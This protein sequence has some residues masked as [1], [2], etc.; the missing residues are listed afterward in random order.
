MAASQ[1]AATPEAVLGI[2]RNVLNRPDIRLDDDVFDHGATSLAFVRVL[3]QI[4]QEFHVM[5]HA[6]ALGGI[7]TSRNLANCVTRELAGTAA[8]SRGA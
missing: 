1:P 8:E 3:A 6:P 5:V 2:V 7:A 4:R